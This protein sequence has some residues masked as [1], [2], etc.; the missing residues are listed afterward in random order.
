MLTSELSEALG[1]GESKARK[2]QIE[3]VQKATPALFK[4]VR[5]RN[6]IAIRNGLGMSEYYRKDKT[7]IADIKGIYPAEKFGNHTDTEYVDISEY[8]SLEVHCVHIEGDPEPLLFVEN[9]NAYIPVYV[10]QADGSSLF[11]DEADRNQPLLYA[12]YKSGLYDRI[13]EL[14]TI[15]WTKTL[16]FGASPTMMIENA[17]KNDKVRFDF[18]TGGPSVGYTPLGSKVSYPANSILSPELFQ[19][20]EDAR[21]RT[22]EATIYGQTLGA[23]LGDNATFSLTSLLSQAGRLPLVSPAQAVSRC[24]TNA[25]KIAFE[26]LAEKGEKH[27]LFGDAKLPETIDITASVEVQLPQDMPKNAAV[28]AQLRGIVPYNLLL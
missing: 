8:W 7:L 13:T 4:S 21:A 23:P 27:A 17:N 2:R 22:Q 20:L 19:L 28:V 12:F 9:D 10:S 25:T 11:E 18:S 3:N 24:I 14:Q 16:E 1:K 15:A 6:G 26:M 5:P